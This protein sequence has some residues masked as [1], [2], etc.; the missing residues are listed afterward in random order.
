M[1]EGLT[2]ES[3]KFERKSEIPM[4]PKPT[5]ETIVPWLP[6]WCF[7]MGWRAGRCFESDKEDWI[8]D[9]FLSCFST[10]GCR[11]DTKS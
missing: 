2:H 3:G 6:S 4:A 7:F 8:V 5:L 11:E 1:P 10:E 9:V